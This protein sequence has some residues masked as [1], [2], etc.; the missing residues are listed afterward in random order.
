M[1]YRRVP[2]F[3]MH[4]FGLKKSRFGNDERNVNNL[5]ELFFT[6]FRLG[7]AQRP[8]VHIYIFWFEMNF[9]FSFSCLL[10]QF[11]LFV[12]W[13]LSSLIPFF[14][15]Y[16]SNCKLNGVKLKSEWNEMS[17]RFR[18]HIHT[19][20]IKRLILA[21]KQIANSIVTLACDGFCIALL[22]RVGV[23][24]DSFIEFVTCL[25]RMR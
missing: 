14:F 20:K 19:H 18:S 3:S 25:C 10:I 16:E 21:N 7:N 4:I 9:R 8:K 5:T 2:P 24:V 22:V 15:F 13:Y 23:V 1:Q 11:I 12:C 6:L 17:V